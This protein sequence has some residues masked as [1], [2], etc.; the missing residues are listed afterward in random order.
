[1]GFLP[2]GLPPDDPFWTDAARPW[3]SQRVWSGEDFPADHA[4]DEGLLTVNPDVW[5]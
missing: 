2:L 3:T 5:G 4:Y 1:V